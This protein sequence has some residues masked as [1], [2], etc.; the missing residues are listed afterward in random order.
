MNTLKCTKIVFVLTIF[1]VFTT[2]FSQSKFKVALDAGHGDHDFGAVYH[3]HIEKNIALAVVLKVGKILE[4]NSGI[5]VI[6]TRKNDVF[7]DLIE[8][9]NIAN[10]ADANIFVSVHCNA[11]K[12][13]EA[14]GCETYVMGMSKNASNLEAARKENKVV[15]LEKDYEQ[16]YKG[17]DPK[18]PETLIGLTMMQEEFLD[19]SIAL[20]G[21]IQREFIDI[22]K[23]SRGVKQ[24]PFMVLHKAYMPRVLIE[25]GFISNPK[26]G[27]ILDSE[28]G[29]NEIA[30]SIANAIIAYKKENYGANDN[31]NIVKPS[32]KVEEVKVVET[33][34]QKPTT[35]PFEVKKP[36]TKPEVKPEV[37]SGVVFKVQLS[38]SS[39]KLD[40][41]PSNFNGLS[42]I[43]M[44]SEGTLYKYM[45]GQTSSYDEAKRLMQEAR[46]KGYTSAFVIAFKD[47][48]KVTVQE[49]LK[50]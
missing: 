5:E 41:V 14:S 42:N 37:T 9:A 46:G 45:Y 8:R 15:L 31:D 11:N 38:A 30:Q 24:A 32:Q 29:Q 48:K 44:S 33:P 4:K 3:G 21:T 13:T 28:E 35:T 49:A 43:S 1:F 12:N 26:E 2:A 25:M 10:R 36:E 19:N 27:A 16:K 50:Q 34:V 22:G 23:K 39:K 40:L 6:Y 20:A 17:F 7:V 47:G 18:S